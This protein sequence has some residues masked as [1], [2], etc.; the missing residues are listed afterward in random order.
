MTDQIEIRLRSTLRSA[1]LPAA[2]DSLRD[3]VHD[4]PAS[5]ASRPA[6]RPSPL[7]LAATV[8]LLVLGLLSAVYLAS[9]QPTPSPEPTVI[10]SPSATSGFHDLLTDFRIS[11][12]VLDRSEG[13][14]DEQISDDRTP[15]TIDLGAIDLAGPFVAALTCR[16]P[17]PLTI[18]FW[19][20][21]PVAVP[22]GAQAT[23]GRM[24]VA[25]WQA[26]CIGGVEFNSLPFLRSEA[27]VHVEVTVPRGASWRVAVGAYPEELV[28]APS[29][30]GS[31][32]RTEGWTLLSDRVHDQ[33]ATNLSPAQ[34][35]VNAPQGATKF[36]VIVWCEGD[37]ELTVTVNL[38]DQALSCPTVQRGERL[39]FELP[40]AGTYSVKAAPEY[41]AWVR[42]LV[43]TDTD[44]VMSRP[45]APPL[46]SAVA[47]AP[48]AAVDSMGSTSE[49]G[50]VA[51]GR[52]GSTEQDVIE[53]G[54]MPV[55]ATASGNFV[56][57]TATDRD[58]SYWIEV[59]TVEPPEFVTTVGEDHGPI[60][61]AFL[62]ATHGRIYYVTWPEPGEGVE[63]RSVAV[64]GTD[65]R[66]LAAYPTDAWNGSAALASD[67]SVLAMFG[68]LG[69]TG[70]ELLVVDTATQATAEHRITGNWPLCDSLSVA[71][72][73]YAAH[74]Y[75]DSGDETLIGRLD[76]GD[77]EARTS[78][79]GG[80]LVGSRDG[81]ILVFTEGTTP[82][83]GSWTSIELSS[84]AESTLFEFG[85]SDPET[86]LAPSQVVLPPGWL[87][88]AGDLGDF[89]ALESGF[90]AVPLLVNVETGDVIRM[91]NLPHD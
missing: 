37:T 66:L 64:D 54:A 45:T 80:T 87:L 5:T 16:G 74:C 27:Q 56:A 10:P 35:T 52:I 67:D 38:V 29:D 72:E 22:T 76:G 61:Q 57:V 63:L 21:G 51:I 18:E 81:P 90:T 40:G 20:P 1:V 8:S 91:E 32:T 33:L 68:C 30:F 13:Q 4:L 65:D 79:F 44:F 53:I 12:V 2:P 46:P 78:A 89:P 77:P 34:V 84:G 7:L 42:M 62:D 58:A 11:E 50:R 43:E 49:H 48:Y 47:N 26:D 19:S 88:F 86:Y 36:G 82:D 15:N 69:G 41:A 6:W 31:L 9:R 71:L 14:P 39:E 28:E 24:T 25:Q 3:F 85:P 59:W 70:C 23:T 17:G 83:G 60:I 75:A 55:Q 73:T